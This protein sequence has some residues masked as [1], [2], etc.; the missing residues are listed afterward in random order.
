MEKATIRK[1]AIRR[2]LSG[3]PVVKVCRELNVSRKWFY[4]WWKRFKSGAKTWYQD[5]SRA[6]QKVANKLDPAMEQLILSVRDELEKTPYAQK[7]ASAIAWQINKLEYSPPPHWTINRVLKRNGRIQTSSSTRKSKN[8]ISYPY[9]T[10]AYYL[11]HIH[12]ADLTGPRYIKGD[13]RFY[14]FNTID[15]FSH[16]AH[17]VVSRSKDDDSVVVALIDTWKNLGIP[18]Y[19]ILDNELSFRG[20][21]RY[22]H[23]LGKVIKLCLSMNV[24]PVFIP[25]AEPW[26]NGIIEHFNHTF[27]KCFYRT[28]RFKSYEHLKRSLKKFIHFHNTN[29]IYAANEGKTPQQMIDNEVIKPNKLDKDYC[30][31]TNLRIPYEGYIHL[32]RFIRS[33][34]KL[35]I[36]GEMFPMPKKVM[37]EYVR[38]T[39]FTEYHLI[40]VFIGD[41]IVAQFEYRLPTLNQE[42]PRI[43]LRELVE[44]M[45]DLGIQIK[46]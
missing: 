17:S 22:P 34:L 14:A 10:E 40:N 23:S 31:P 13:G 12:N 24:Q 38:A 18:E 37:Y 15:V 8:S 29:H 27:D 3:E 6:P 21:N 11:G 28:D 26:R 1:E 39:I 43:L 4:K 20:S 2:H 5:I 46:R 7:G 35:N 33:D 41:E 42:N 19:L 30:L 16:S 45:K 36:W 25:P 44:S 32:I 9:F